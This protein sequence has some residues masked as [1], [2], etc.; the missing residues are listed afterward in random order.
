VLYL[1]L[2]YLTCILT[3]GD[4]ISVVY[5]SI[6]SSVCI[7]VGSGIFWDFQI[8]VVKNQILPSLFIH[9]VTLLKDNLVKR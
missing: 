2:N 3:F 5:Y 8:R 9:F 7:M 1:L 6:S 4:Q